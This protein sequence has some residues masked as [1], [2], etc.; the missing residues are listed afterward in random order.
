[1]R[2]LS[3]ASEA[4]PIASAYPGLHNN[5]VAKAEDVPSSDSDGGVEVVS[6]KPRPP[7]AATGAIASRLPSLATPTFASDIASEVA[8]MRA[9]NLGEELCNN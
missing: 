6:V 5:E 2:G 1:M 3:T 4:E 7:E 8:T 9:P